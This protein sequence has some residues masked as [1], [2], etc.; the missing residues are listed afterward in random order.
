MHDD[1]IGRLLRVRRSGQGAALNAVLRIHRRVLVG[2]LG[3]S[4]S[5]DPDAETRAVH[6][7]EHRIEPLVGLADQPAGG[8]VEDHLAGGVAVDAHLVLDATAVQPVTRADRGVLA[9]SGGHELRH[10][11]QR[12]SFRP[13]RRVRQARQHEVHDVLRHVVFAG[14]NKDLLSG[15][16]IAAV[17]LRL[18][19]RAQHA[20]IGSA[21]RLGEAHRAGPLSRGELRQI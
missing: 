3:Q 6:H 8:A 12:D 21:V 13:V 14:G 19:F 15:Q 5:L 11:E 4:Q 20:E 9:A 2:N 17:G 1:R 18:G 16:P 7:H 10:D